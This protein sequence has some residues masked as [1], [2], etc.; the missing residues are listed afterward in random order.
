MQA[1]QTIT[2]I[3]FEARCLS[4][5]EKVNRTGEPLLV[6]RNGKLLQIS[7]CYATDPHEGNTT[8]SNARMRRGE[9]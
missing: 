9:R 2:D 5:L 3:E 4:I 7:P 6:S 8:E 1:M